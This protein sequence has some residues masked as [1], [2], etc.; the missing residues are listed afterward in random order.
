MDNFYNKCPA[1]MDDG[2]FVS[3][4]KSATRRN[5]YIK[6]INNID[7]D[8]QFRSFLQNNANTIMDNVW[9]HHEQNDTCSVNR[10][11][12][13]FP[14]R[15]TAAQLN[16]EMKIYNSAQKPACTKLENYRATNTNG[17]DLL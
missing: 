10:C 13:T 15:C 14:T 9:N 16:A 6:Y 11:V 8:D 5:E 1:M 3:D 4:Y 2:R 12:H 7:R 17:Q